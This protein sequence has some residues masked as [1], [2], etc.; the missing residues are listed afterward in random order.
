MKNVFQLELLIA[1]RESCQARADVCAVGA[2]DIPVS[3]HR[4]VWG[5]AVPS[6]EARSWENSEIFFLEDLLSQPSCF[7]LEKEHLELPS[8]REIDH[9]EAQEGLV[10]RC[11]G[12]GVW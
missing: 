1:V 6:N 8:P 11:H 12:M 7:H 9:F 3:P 2:P 5:A 10:G 4:R